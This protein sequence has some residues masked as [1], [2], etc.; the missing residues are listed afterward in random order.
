MELMLWTYPGTF[1]GHDLSQR[2]HYFLG[3]LYISCAAYSGCPISSFTI[4][5]LAFGARGVADQS[6][7]LPRD[8]ICQRCSSSPQCGRRPS[9]GS[10]NQRNVALTLWEA[11]FCQGAGGNFFRGSLCA[12]CRVKLPYIPTPKDI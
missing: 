8:V 10:S 6:A 12:F 1:Q 5:C 9:V 7:R 11:F 3:P 4:V 2:L